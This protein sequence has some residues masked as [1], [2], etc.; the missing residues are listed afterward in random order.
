METML[1][2]CMQS[3]TNRLPINA[4]HSIKYLQYDLVLP[5][6]YLYDFLN[7]VIFKTRRL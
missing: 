1:P 6:K 4:D 5:D 7:S 3:V 2:Q